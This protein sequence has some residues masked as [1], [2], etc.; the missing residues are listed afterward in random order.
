[1]VESCRIRPTVPADLGA[2]TL[3]EQAAFSDPWTSEMLI[4]AMTTTGAISLAAT[5]ASGMIIGSVLGRVAADEGEILSIAV[6][7]QARGIGL[8]RALLVRALDALVAGGAASVW[9]E[10]R[11][12]NEAAKA[13]YRAV[14]FQAAGIRRGYY[15]RPH[16][17]ALVL[18]WRPPAPTGTPPQ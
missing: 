18:S 5:D 8:G 12:S 2:L 17:D 15:R 14:G 16:E 11:P 4:E 7:P 13:M 1:M 9:L 6:A 10:V 3:L